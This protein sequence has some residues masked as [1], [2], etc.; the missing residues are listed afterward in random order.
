MLKRAVISAFVLLG[1]CANAHERTLS[2]AELIATHSVPSQISNAALRASG[3][4]L[5]KPEERRKQARAFDARYGARVLRLAAV[6]N[7][8]GRA[9][10][11]FIV[12]TPCMRPSR[13]Q[14]EA[15]LA[16]FDG[17]LRAMGTE[18]HTESRW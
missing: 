1:G 2:A 15:D 9:K 5:C 17:S 10:S 3:Y 6:I 13:Q 11:E 12:V 18:W 8:S 4:W 14:R 16:G 7:A